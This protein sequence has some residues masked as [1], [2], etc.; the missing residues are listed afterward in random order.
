MKE[1]VKLNI[2]MVVGYFVLSKLAWALAI[3]PGN[4]TAFWPASGWALGLMLRYQKIGLWPGIFIGNFLGNT[5]MFIDISTLESTMIGL[6]TGVGIGIGDTLQTVLG[7]ILIRGI[8]IHKSFKGYLTV[9]LLWKIIGIISLTHLFSPS[10]GVGS[11]Y[12]GK[13]LRFDVVPYTWLTWYTG[14]LL[15]ALILTPAVSLINKDFVKCL[16][17]KNFVITLLLPLLSFLILYFFNSTYYLF[18]LF[19]LIVLIPLTME[20]EYS[21]IALNLMVI[22]SIIALDFKISSRVELNNSLIIYQSVI[23]VVF[24][25][26]GFILISKGEKEFLES[27]L[28]IQRKITAHRSRLSSLGE[29]SAGIAHELNNPLSIIALTLRSIDK[30]FNGNRNEAVINKSITSSK[31]AIDRCTKIIKN[32]RVFSREG[33]GEKEIIDIQEIINESLNLTNSLTKENG[34]KVVFDSIHSEAIFVDCNR[35]TIEQVLVNII[36]NAVHACLEATTN[37][38]QINIKLSKTKNTVLIRIIDSGNGISEEI[39][40]RLFDPFFTT[41]QVGSGTGLGLSI[42]NGIILSHG[43]E[44]EYELFEGHTSFV[45]RLPIVTPS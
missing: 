17:F 10:F 21:F 40:S 39:E 2:L 4:V 11:L 36:Q 20:K 22:A 9:S 1:I 45:I 29:M 43:G 7:Y 44:L 27:E 28:E 24:Y 25:V 35:I 18:Y 3:E 19:P 31:K 30:E 41:K 23:F 8:F 42:S 26:I 13:F 6:T 33:V 32:L 15:G 5:P 37:K 34:I 12:L 16:G 14:D 38:K